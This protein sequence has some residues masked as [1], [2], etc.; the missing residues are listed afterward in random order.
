MQLLQNTQLSLSPDAVALLVTVLW[1]GRGPFDRLRCTLALTMPTDFRG[2]FRPIV[3]S[4]SGFCPFRL[5]YPRTEETLL[6][7]GEPASGPWWRFGVWF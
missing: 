6:D 7:E 3:R 2:E 5:S 1:V 4:Q